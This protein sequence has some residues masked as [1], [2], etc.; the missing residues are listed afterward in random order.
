MRWFRSLLPRFFHTLEIPRRRSDRRAYRITGAG[1]QS[2]GLLPWYFYVCAG[3]L[4]VAAHTFTLRT[5]LPIVTDLPD[6]GEIVDEDILAP[7]SFT[8]PLLESDVEM[9]QLQKVLVEPPVVRRLSGRAERSIRAVENL[10][11]AFETH[12]N[13]N[14]LPEAER[15]GL[16]EIRF[17]DLLPADIRYA[18]TNDIPPSLFSRVKA[19]LAQ[20]YADG[21]VDNLPPGNYRNVWI[22]TVNT[23]VAFDVAAMIEQKDITDVMIEKLAAEDLPAGD[24]TWVA[25][26]VRPLIEADLVY[27]PEDTR[28]HRMAARESVPRSREFIEGER[29]VASGERVSELSALFLETLKSEMVDR[30]AHAPQGPTT[31]R[32][33]VRAGVVAGM[34]VFFAWL[35]HLYFRA[36]LVDV[37]SLVSV[38]GVL[39]IFILISSYTLRNPSLGPYTVPI[40]WLAVL[41]TT[42]Y[43]SRIGYGAT[44]FAVALL[45]L[46]PD[47]QSWW[48]LGWLMEGIMAVTL[49]R[50]IRNRD[51]FYKAIAVLS[52]LS[53]ALITAFEFLGGGL[54]TEIWKLYALGVLTPIV[55]V[56][57]ALFLLPIIEPLVGA[58]S[59]LTLLELSDLNHPLLRKLSLESQGTFHHSLVA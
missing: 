19:V 48:M 43:R 33:L 39:T 37:R 44:I 10:L 25:N 7:F 50:Q 59:D 26:L 57:V 47:V 31:L 9:M 15:I 35:A 49:I 52:V 14:V 54:S 56:A 18:F 42:L 22:K 36:I 58:C 4:V 3:L 29:I 55:S 8:A 20:Q 5:E 41:L 21:I 51:Q 34:L 28:A 24:V 40:H 45:A 2:L 16:L 11:N 17:P 27:S 32:V 13:L 12:L 30:G 1:S 46:M 38:A 53:L 23:E 6:L